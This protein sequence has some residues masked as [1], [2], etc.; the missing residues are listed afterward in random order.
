MFPPA[1]EIPKK[2]AEKS[3]RVERFYI[4]ARIHGRFERIYENTVVGYNRIV[5]ADNISTDCVRIGITD[6]RTEPTLSFIGFYKG[7]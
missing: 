1:Q 7:E 3:Q 6:S 5:R 4:E 2:I